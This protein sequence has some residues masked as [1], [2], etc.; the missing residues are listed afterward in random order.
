MLLVTNTYNALATSYF[1]PQPPV[2]YNW[3]IIEAHAAL[4]WWAPAIDLRV[5]RAWRIASLAAPGAWSR[6]RVGGYPRRAIPPHRVNA[7]LEI[8]GAIPL[9]ITLSCS[10]EATREILALVGPRIWSLRLTELIDKDERDAVRKCVNLRQL[11]IYI[12]ERWKK[13]RTYHLPIVGPTRTQLYPSFPHLTSL[14]L[15]LCCVP[16]GVRYPDIPLQQLRLKYVKGP[17]TTLI[18]RYRKSLRCLIV[19]WC[20]SDGARAP[21][22]HLPNL[23]HLSLDNTR[24][25]R[26]K[27]TAPRLTVFRASGDIQSPY[28]TPAFWPSV[29]EYASIDA[30]RGNGELLFSTIC[31][32]PQRSEAAAP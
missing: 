6:F 26:R 10:P 18:H 20:S 5:S 7:W 27:I 11:D 24:Q 17:F 9:E 3:L 13:F 16:D 22:I 14:S 8:S 30:F 31:L 23:V 2:R 15:G 4:E 1:L 28:T 29:E 19:A 32:N 25:L 12:R 21:A